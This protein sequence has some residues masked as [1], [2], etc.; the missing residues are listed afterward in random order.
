MASKSKSAQ[1]KSAAKPARAK[2][3]TPAPTPA[4]PKSPPVEAPAKPPEPATTTEATAE[5][6][7]RIRLVTPSPIAP[8]VP[9]TTMGRA[10]RPFAK[11]AQSGSFSPWAVTQARRGR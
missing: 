6:A 7:R 1:A 11:P 4:A 5:P 10:I 3:N 9:Q 8:A 2:R